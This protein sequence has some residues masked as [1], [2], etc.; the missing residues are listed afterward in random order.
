[1]PLVGFELTIPVFEQVKT[2]EAL[3]RAVII[4]HT[5]KREAVAVSV[6]DSRQV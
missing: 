5:A 6:L 4:I 1:M 3:D 2:F